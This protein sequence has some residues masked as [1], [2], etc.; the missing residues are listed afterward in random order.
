MTPAEPHVGAAVL[1]A[2]PANSGVA[3]QCCTVLAHGIGT[4]SDLPVP[5]GLAAAAA[6]ATLVISFA[7]LAVLWRSP[8]RRGTGRPLPAGL[9]AVLDAA[10]LRLGLQLLTLAAAVAVVTV[11]L[12]GP[13]DP[14]R[15]LAPWAFYVTFWVG[16]VPASLLLGPVWRVL[17]P[18]RLLHRAV[19]AML[20]ID[21]GAGVRELPE[22]IGY[23]PAAVSLAVFGWFEL[24]FPARAQP[25]S[26]AV[27][28]LAY[29][30]VHLAAATVFGRRWFDRGDG[31]EVYSVLVGALA[32]LGRRAG[33]GRLVLRNPLDG[34]A[35]VPLAPGLVGVV[36]ALLGATAYDGLSRTQLWNAL[37]PPGLATGTGG[38]LLAFVL[39]G[40][41]FGLGTFTVAS[42]RPSAAGGAG[43]PVAFAPT[44]APIAAGYAIAHYFSLLVF[45]GQQVGI[46]ASD[47]L[48]TGA[49]L[50]GTAGRTIDYTVVGT[51]TIA[52]VQLGG[53][54]LGHLVA[55]ASA[56]DQAY[57]LF[58]RR[59][60]LRTQYP[61]LAAMVT[62]TIG[63]VGLVFAA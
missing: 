15:N 16:I 28:L 61:M 58:P 45:D 38:L 40:V 22:K 26:V 7:V 4:R 21:P 31:F 46:L 27:F 17:N 59:V 54:V 50:L 8:R 32:P 11:G 5:V 53:I 52:L 24:A 35:A 18:L 42:T 12:A 48:G 10:P 6:A 60:A 43:G 33:D 49:D 36:V 14:A 55:A 30:G 34:L 9:A 29:A 25:V 47:P 62:L 39:V 37:V 56:H 63:A 44:L 3:P 2:G 1:V 20:R 57:R 51:T 41:V 13:P 23:W 19:A